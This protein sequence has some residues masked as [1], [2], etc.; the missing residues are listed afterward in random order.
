MKHLASALALVILWASTLSAQELQFQFS[1]PVTLPPAHEDQLLAVRL[2]A[3]VF[4]ATQNDFADVRLFD[5][6]GDQVPYVVHKAQTSRSNTTRKVWPGRDPQLKPLEDGGLEITLRLQK[7]DPA[8]QGLKLVTPLE[9]F[10][11]RVRV[12]ASADGEQWDPLGGEVVIFDYS[13]FMDVRQDEISFPESDRRQLRI[14]IDNVTAEQEN[15]LV[16]LTRRLAG[17][18]ETERVE[19][20]N[21]RRRPFRI[22]RVDFWRDLQNSKFVGPELATHAITDLQVEQ[23]QERKQTL[24]TFITQR[25]PLTSLKVDVAERNFSRPMTLETA[26]EQSSTGW[27][28]L[29]GSTI[30]RI[31]FKQLQ[32]GQLSISFPE[33]RESKYRLVIEN[34]DSP[35]LT[36]TGITASGPVYELV[37]LPESNSTF[38]LAYGNA[39]AKNPTYDTAAVEEILRTGVTPMIAELGEQSAGPPPVTP[40]RVSIVRAL[41]N[42]ILLAA[43]VAVL[44]GV[45]GWALY[46]A[47]RRIENMP[48][49]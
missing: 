47:A 30:S 24:V 3:E 23:D 26:S 18:N 42:P 46:N 40:A 25:Q 2:D 7:D 4:A 1:K 5:D 34:H 36:I 45:L 9:N 41:T 27:R 37:F 6:A 17:E 49:E 10:E 39:D 19:R 22:D 21:V 38:Q 43:V 44:I 12:F 20:T 35:P 15:E 48:S 11:Q 33:S 8:P 29:S 28:R 16:E 13:R 31:D 32:R 14:V